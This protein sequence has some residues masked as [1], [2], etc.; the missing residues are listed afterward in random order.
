L[1]DRLVA[2]ISDTSFSGRRRDVDRIISTVRG[3]DAKADETEMLR[4][5]IEKYV[6][7]DELISFIKKFELDAGSSL[8]TKQRKVFGESFSI[9]DKRGHAISNAAKLL[10]HVRNAIVHSSDRYKREDCHIPLSDTEFIIGDYI[11]ILK[12][13][14]E[15]VIFGTAD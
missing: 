1:S 12:F 2:L 10:K 15:K 5:V 6:D 4:S 11:P 8:Y 7:E 13:I 14:A 3:Q 9:Q